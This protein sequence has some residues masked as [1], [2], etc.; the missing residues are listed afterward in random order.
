MQ[1]S[2]CA[3]DSNTMMKKKI[4]LYFKNLVCQIKQKLVAKWEIVGDE[5]YVTNAEV[6]SK[7]P[8][9]SILVWRQPTYDYF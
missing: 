3:N 6:S 1:Y 9:F 8:H 2:A 7:I 4:N 5:W